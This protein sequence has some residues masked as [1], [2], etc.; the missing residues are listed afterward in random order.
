ML[1][2]GLLKPLVAF[3]NILGSTSQIM[4]LAPDIKKRFAISSPNPWAPPVTIAVLSLKSKLIL[5]IR[6]SLASK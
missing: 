5:F 2:L 6:Y 1:K 4:T 3:S